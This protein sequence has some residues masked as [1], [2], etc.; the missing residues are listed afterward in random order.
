MQRLP[1]Q[2]SLRAN[3]DY[4]SS[5]VSQQRYQQDI[6]RA[7]NRNAR[8]GGNVTGSWSATTSQRHGRP[9]RLLLHGDVAH[10]LREL[11]RV[12]FSPAERPIGRF[13]GLFRRQRRIRHAAR[14]SSVDDVTTQDR[15]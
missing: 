4:F 6:A 3:A 12:N 2:F 9:D 15:A 7:T 10:D 14:S 5:I 1:V 13:A 8:F 11:P